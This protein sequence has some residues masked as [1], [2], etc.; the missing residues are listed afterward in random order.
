MN[1]TLERYISTNTVTLCFIFKAL[2]S[3]LY[4]K[5]IVTL[6]TWQIDSLVPFVT[7]PVKRLLNGHIYHL[8]PT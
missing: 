8:H 1:D 2:F 6:H 7:H 4:L 3:S 5:S